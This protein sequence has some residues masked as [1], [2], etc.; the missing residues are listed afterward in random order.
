M[1]R[2]EIRDEMLFAP[3]NCA[4]LYIP[5][6][7]SSSLADGSTNA[8]ANDGVN[9]R[10]GLVERLRTS[11]TLLQGNAPLTRVGR[12]TETRLGAIGDLRRC[13][14]CGTIRAVNEEDETRDPSSC[15]NSSCSSHVESQSASA[16]S[17]ESV[18]QTLDTVSES[19]DE[20]QT[21]DSMSESSFDVPTGAWQQNLPA[22]TYSSDSI[23]ES[24]FDVTAST[25]QA[26]PTLT[27]A[28]TSDLISIFQQVVHE[29]L[30]RVESTSSSYWADE[31]ASESND[32]SQDNASLN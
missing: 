16:S 3:F 15:S 1:Q 24:S 4:V 2:I 10:P 30:Y 29:D 23:S 13:V 11:S 5:G 27:Y 14:S 25:W 22:L 19:R 21:Q 17:V 7:S 9:T 31:S 32:D 8:D 26:P 6:A 18:E 20:T 28:I 12:N